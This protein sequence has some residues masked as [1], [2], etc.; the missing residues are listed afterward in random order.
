MK[1]TQEAWRAMETHVPQQAHT[2]GISNIYQIEVLKALYDFASVKPSVV[3]NRF[4]PNTG[5]DTEIRAFCTEK[6]MTY[7]SFW[8]LTGSE[9]A[10]FRFEALRFAMCAIY[11]NHTPV[12]YRSEAIKLETSHDTRGAGH[13]QLSRGAVQPC[14]RARQYKCTQRNDEREEDGKRLPSSHIIAMRLRY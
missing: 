14:A 13:S 7:Q 1:E 3:Q 10:T 9:C 11:A 6:G 4:Y 8:T 5:Y 12:G 2:L